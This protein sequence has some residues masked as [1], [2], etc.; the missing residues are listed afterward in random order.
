MYTPKYKVRM[1]HFFQI[2]VKLKNGLEGVDFMQLKVTR[3]ASRFSEVKYHAHQKEEREYFY[4]LE[5]HGS[6]AFHEWD[7]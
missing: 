4:L 1:E 5:L 2:Y 6:S 3:L 7:T